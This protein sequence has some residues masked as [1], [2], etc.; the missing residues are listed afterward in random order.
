MD[1]Q[2]KPGSVLGPTGRL[3]GGEPRDW[4]VEKKKCVSG[5]VAC[6]HAEVAPEKGACDQ[7]LENN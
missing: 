7:A 3:Q 2:G 4:A 5:Q 1:V 6:S